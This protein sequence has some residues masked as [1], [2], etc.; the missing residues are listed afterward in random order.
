[1][2]SQ[3]ENCY[4]TMLE[5]IRDMILKDEIRLRDVPPDV[6]RSSN[7]IYEAAFRAGRSCSCR[8]FVSDV[9][10]LC[11]DIVTL[12]DTDDRRKAQLTALLSDTLQLSYYKGDEYF[13]DFK[14]D[15]DESVL[16]ELH[17]YEYAHGK[18]LST[19]FRKYQAENRTG[20]IEK[21]QGT[22]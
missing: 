1:M 12:Y 20:R 13:E 15:M 9:K 4:R 19:L 5:W 11:G 8:R 3:L 6:R 10:V 2:N 7:S 16:R 21:N 18:Q 14:R 22:E 17:R